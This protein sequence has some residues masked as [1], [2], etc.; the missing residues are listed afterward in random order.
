MLK[1]SVICFRSA[2]SLFPRVVSGT[3]GIGLINS[4]VRSAASCVS[5]SSEDIL[6]NGR[7]SGKN[8][9]VLE[10]RY[11]TVLGILGVRQRQYSISGI[12]YQP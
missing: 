11:L 1:I 3:V 2:V 7:V 5:V 12:T 4:F 6:G 10:T 9:V 8:S